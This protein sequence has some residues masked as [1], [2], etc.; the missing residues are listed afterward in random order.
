[1]IL[2]DALVA[3]RCAKPLGGA[4]PSVLVVRHA[5]ALKSGICYG[6]SE[7]EVEFPPPTAAE[8]VMAGYPELGLHIDALW[9]SPLERAQH[10]AECLAGLCHRE[11]HLDPRLAET[12]FGDW[13]GYS[14]EDIYRSDRERFEQWANDPMRLGPPNGES[15][16]DLVAR[17]SAWTRVI[18]TKRVLA[19]THAGPIRVLRALGSARHDVTHLSLD[20]ER[21]V[22]HLAVEAIVTTVPH[23]D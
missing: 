6:R 15:G 13:E 3:F 12:N 10:L 5:K 18:G 16:N 7:I 19:V 9:T 8:R 2:R 22:P 20:F 21:T 23:N 11:L 4:I 14:W 17:I 1:V